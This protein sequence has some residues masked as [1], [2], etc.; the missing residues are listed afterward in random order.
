M[1]AR[2]AAL[3]VEIRKAENPLFENER[4]TAVCAKCGDG[5]N[6][7][8]ILKRSTPGDVNSNRNALSGVL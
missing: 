1:E 6:F 5:G 2:R 4:G 8:G 3:L 7:L